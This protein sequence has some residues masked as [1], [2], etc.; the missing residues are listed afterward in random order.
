MDT[1]TQSAAMGNNVSG[2]AK[3]KMT[4]KESV[5]NREI[6][7]VQDVE[8]NTKSRPTPEPE[9]DPDF[10]EE[11]AEMEGP[12]VTH[13]EDL[14]SG[15]EDS[16]LFAEKPN[17][18]T[19][20]STESITSFEEL[21]S[22]S[23]CIG[24]K[25][26]ETPSMSGCEA[27]SDT[28]REW[29]SAEGTPAKKQRGISKDLD[30]I[31][32][33]DDINVEARVV[34]EKKKHDIQE[35]PKE[36]PNDIELPTDILST[37][38]SPVSSA[39]PDPVEIG[40]IEGEELMDIDEILG[41]REIL[42]DSSDK[43]VVESEAAV[44]VV[45]PS[46]LE[47]KSNA[48]VTEELRDEKD[49]TKCIQPKVTSTTEKNENPEEVEPPKT[50]EDDRSDDIQIID[51]SDDEAMEI[52]KSDDKM[53]QHIPMTEIPTDLLTEKNVELASGTTDK[54]E[55]ESIQD[56][57]IDIAASGDGPQNI[58]TAIEEPDKEQILNISSSV[59]DMSLEENIDKEEPQLIAETVTDGLTKDHLAMETNKD[60]LTDEN[61]R[62]ESTA[63][64]EISHE[65]EFVDEAPSSPSQKLSV[66]ETETTSDLIAQTPDGMDISEGLPE[67]L[68]TTELQDPNKKD[69][70][71]EEEETTIELEQLPKTVEETVRDILNESLDKLLLSEM[72][73][74][75]EETVHEDEPHDLPTSDYNDETMDQNP[76]SLDDYFS[77]DEVRAEA[78]A[79]H[80]EELKPSESP[81]LNE[82][83]AFCYDGDV[84]EEKQNIVSKATVK[85][86]SGLCINPNCP[87]VDIQEFLPVPTFARSFYNVTQREKGKV[88]VC[89][90]CLDE[91]VGRY[92]ALWD[93][94][95]SSSLEYSDIIQQADLEVICSSDEEEEKEPK[96]E[97][98]LVRIFKILTL[99]LP[100]HSIFLQM[101]LKKR[102]MKMI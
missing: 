100:N 28:D 37:K 61:E 82:F 86:S 50:Q 5:S 14:S 47:E 98:K 10:A 102:T 38:P 57:P 26:C 60:N 4:D 90:K 91:C 87:Q 85:R 70:K 36:H 71:S 79:D 51:D 53:E 96:D 7:E 99:Q 42:S 55:V 64:K 80:A 16:E 84:D 24:E 97:G 3:E 62:K 32:S 78:K 18:L 33:E 95:E 101:R 94:F 29:E 17:P 22:T 74:S 67:S 46:D 13:A 40:L 68:Q 69:D 63:D 21:P 44:D 93:K 92:G 12:N 27:I 75:D 89:N 54:I 56:I 8:T 41:D 81:L 76:I 30:D 52:I 2:Q 15:D 66:S 19:R 9:P 83:E 59:E 72:P 25:R 35:K 65:I 31:D 1:T 23:N 88:N 58:P 73:G 77:D 49:E 39:E 43:S 34:E 11:L 20:L 45:K 48:A 6:S